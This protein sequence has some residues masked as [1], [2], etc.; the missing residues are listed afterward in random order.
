M[1]TGHSVRMAVWLLIGIN[2]L[3]AYGCV[4]IF[5][6]MAPVIVEINDRN[7][8]SMGACEEMLEVLSSRDG[9]EGYAV[10]QLALAKA[11]NNVTEKDEAPALSRIATHAQ[12]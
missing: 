11:R 4:W 6:R 2:L 10:F 12:Q 7:L 3:M 1:K 5:M 9:A 8:R